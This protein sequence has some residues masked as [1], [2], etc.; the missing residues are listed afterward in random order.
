[1]T[2]ENQIPLWLLAVFGILGI[3]V[4]TVYFS[5]AASE[6]LEVANSSGAVTNVLWPIAAIFIVGLILLVALGKRGG[7]DNE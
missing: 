1:L 2:E 6:A 3:S 7:G 5:V 4:I